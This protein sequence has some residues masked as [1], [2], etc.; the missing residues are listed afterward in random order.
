MNS[1][2]FFYD[3]MYRSAVPTPA[4]VP[5]AYRQGAPDNDRQR[6]QSPPAASPHGQ[7]GPNAQ[8][9]DNGAR[10]NPATQEGE[11]GQ[12]KGHEQGDQGDGERN[13]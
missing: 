7:Q 2:C 9:Q 4:P 5:T 1:N 11:R 3:G 13:R 8:G 6:P 12:A 10:G